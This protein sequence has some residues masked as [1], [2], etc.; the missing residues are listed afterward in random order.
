MLSLDIITIPLEMP[1]QHYNQLT[2]YHHAVSKN[3]CVAILDTDSSLNECFN[4]ICINRI[5]PHITKLALELLKA[6]SF[7]F[8]NT[9]K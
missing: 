5:L 9:H 7:K 4:N 2:R 8:N 3:S 6:L 1:S